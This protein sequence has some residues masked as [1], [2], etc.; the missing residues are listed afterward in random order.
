MPSTFLLMLG[1]AVFGASMAI[2]Q[3]TTE[4]VA[5]IKPRFLAKLDEQFK[6]A[7]KNG[8][9]ALTKTEAESANMGRI[10]DNFDQLDANK[11]GKVTREE[12][13]SLVRQRISS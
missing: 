3:S 8:D 7:D 10:V 6:A 13:R 1:A 4:Q 2:A 9:S 12:V 11:D 5:E